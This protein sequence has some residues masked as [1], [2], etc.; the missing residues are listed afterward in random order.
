MTMS[1]TIEASDVLATLRVDD[2]M[3]AADNSREQPGTLR[4]FKESAERT[5][6]RGDAPRA[7]LE[8]FE[9]G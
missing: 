6:P 1:D 9:D 5:I 2:R 7:R 4:E 3:S 8:Y